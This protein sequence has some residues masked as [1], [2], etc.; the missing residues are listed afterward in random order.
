MAE[1]HGVGGGNQRSTEEIRKDIAAK[2]ESISDA[3]GQLGAKIQG[4]FDWRGYVVRRP[5]AAVGV[6]AGAGLL[7]GSLVRRKQTP[8]ERIKNALSDAADDVARDL[9]K[10]LGGF[11][12]KAGASVRARNAVTGIVS[13]TVASYIHSRFIDGHR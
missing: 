1:E 11:G 6:A 2:R 12:T 8:F 10:S 3:V 13:K 4:T 7:V 5:Y 9:R